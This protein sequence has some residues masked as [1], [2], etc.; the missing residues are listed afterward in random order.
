MRYF[1]DPYFKADIQRHNRNMQIIIRKRGPGS[2]ELD[3]DELA[4]RLRFNLTRYEPQVQKIEVY[5][6]P[7]CSGGV[8]NHLVRIR[9]SLSE[10]PDIHVEDTE[11]DL[12][13][14]VERAIGRATRLVR[15]RIASNLASQGIT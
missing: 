12:C 1:F 10:F 2:P 3:R 8:E 5:S 6:E 7:D 4:G 15:Q 13:V 11:T 14:A 9:I